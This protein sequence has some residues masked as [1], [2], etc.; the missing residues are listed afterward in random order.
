MVLVELGDGTTEKHLI[1]ELS[2][3]LGADASMQAVTKSDVGL[4]ED[5][6]G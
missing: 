1:T 5:T 2:I 3:G 6:A 4:T